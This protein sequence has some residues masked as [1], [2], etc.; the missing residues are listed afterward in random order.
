MSAQS[1]TL[2]DLVG[3]WSGQNALWFEPGTPAFE[4]DATARIELTAGGR[5]LVMDYTWS[6]EGKEHQGHLVLRLAEAMSAVDAIWVDSFHQSGAF[7]LMAGVRSTASSHSARGSYPAPT[8]P[9][10][11]WRVSLDAESPERCVMRMFNITPD[12][13]EADAVRME[14]HRR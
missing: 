8:G 9:D 14:L 1:T 4:S 6:H 13:E 12:G 2:R 5:Y 11:G 10:W 7:L 3:T